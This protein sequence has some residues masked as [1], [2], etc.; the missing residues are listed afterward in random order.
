MR[1]LLSG[2]LILVLGACS[3][4]D[5]KTDDSD[6]TKSNENNEKSDQGNETV[7]TFPEELLGTFRYV[8]Y[9]VN[10]NDTI[11]YLC[12][13]ASPSLNIKKNPD[14]LEQVICE[15]T[16]FYSEYHTIAVAGEI[17]EDGFSLTEACMVYPDCEAYQSE[18]KNYKNGL[19]FKDG[20]F[21]IAEKDVRQFEKR[22]CGIISEDPLN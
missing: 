13:D 7:N 1:L 16:D 21:C 4:G 11:F 20:E 18:W 22:H 9:D 17:T 8:F 2:I 5:K 19:F 15:H 10:E 14:N 6:N 12:E 3:E